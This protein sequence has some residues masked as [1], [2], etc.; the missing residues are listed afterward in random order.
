[1]S[2]DDFTGASSSSSGGGGGGGRRD[3]RIDFS[4]P[5]V[6]VVRDTMGQI[7]SEVG[8]VRVI[9]PED[10]IEPD[11]EILCRFTE[12]RNWVAF[13][14]NVEKEY[15]LDADE[16]LETNPERIPEIK[17]DL[18]KPDPPSQTRTCVVCGEEM[19]P[20]HSSFTELPIARDGIA[21]SGADKLPV[22]EHHSIGELLDA[23][24]DT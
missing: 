14:D 3:T 22:H 4:P 9:R 16:I 11:Y 18:P 15:G 10:D 2:L 12:R 23:N 24:S 13:R 7:N 5:H 6:M 20:A 21:A 17:S 1:M 8:G 19:N